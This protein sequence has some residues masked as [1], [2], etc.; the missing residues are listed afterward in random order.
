LTNNF[1]A[2]AIKLTLASPFR[3]HEETTY[4]N[5]AAID[6][7]TGRTDRVGATVMLASGQVLQ[8]AETPE[9]ILGALSIGEQ[10]YREMAEKYAAAVQAQQPMT[11]QE[12]SPIPSA[13]PS[14]AA[15]DTETLTPAG[16]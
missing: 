9:E 12:G 10:T 11:Y 3:D 1:N 16:T 4:V 13:V 5:S 8:V 14:Q 6:Q 15:E 2:T 7:V